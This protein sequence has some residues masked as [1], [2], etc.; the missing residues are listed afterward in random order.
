MSFPYYPIQ[1]YGPLMKGMVIGGLG[2]FH[3]FLA[4]FAIGGGFLMCY[5]QYLSQKRRV[6]GASSFL[7][8]YFKFLVLISFVMGALTGVG[9]WFTTIQVSPR[10]I[11]LMVEEFHWIWAIEWVFFWVEVISGYLYYRYSAKLSEDAKLKLLLVYSFAAWG[12]LFWINGILSWQLTPSGWLETKNVWRGFFN[13]SFFPSLLFRTAAALTTAGLVGCIVINSLSSLP[14]ESR[15]FL[16]HKCTHFMLPL[17][18][19][20]FIGLWYFSVIPS[21]S[22]SWVMGGSVA[23]TMFLGIALSASVL[24]AGYAFIG[25]WYK[26][27]YINGATAALLTLLAFGATAGGEFVREG[28]RKPYTIREYLYSNSITPDA[29][30]Q[31]REHGSVTNDPYP[32]KLSSQYP[33]SQLALGAKVFRFQ[34]LVCH[35]ESGANG[36]THLTSTWNEDML[37]QNIAHLESLKTFMPPFAGNIEELEALVQWIRWINAGK[38]KSFVDTSRIQAINEKNREYLKK[39]AVPSPISSSHVNP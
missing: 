34:C 20:P 37:R 27:L 31:M 21:D 3:V 15:K 1:D 13:P 36:M 39:D 32:I 28:I 25:L 14:R 18:L 2:I 23:M 19:M 7:H 29:V 4:Q 26:R 17:G 38:P 12:S 9:M 16:I 6:E 24:I 30:A 33:N 22:R 8:S 10:T 35:T 11:G 5:F